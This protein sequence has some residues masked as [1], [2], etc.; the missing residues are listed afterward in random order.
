MTTGYQDVVKEDA[1]TRPIRST[2]EP[3]TSTPVGP[4]ARPTRCS[5]QASCTT[6]VCSSTSDS[7][8]TP[9]PEIF[10][11][12]V[13]TC[14]SPGRAGIP[15]ESANF[16]YASI[17]ASAGPRDTNRDTNRDQRRRLG[18]CDLDAV[19]EEPSGYDVTVTPSF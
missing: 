8:V 11:D 7:S 12:P 13:A 15:I 16:N 9:T 6:P 4:A 1:S 2:W 10:V 5:T 17:G 14:D 3:G 18:R 19:V